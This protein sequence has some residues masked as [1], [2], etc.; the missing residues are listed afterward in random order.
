MIAKLN[1]LGIELD[2][3]DNILFYNEGSF[4]GTPCE[5][6]TDIC[7]SYGIDVDTE[8]IEMNL[9]GFNHYVD[10]FIDENQRE[11]YHIYYRDIKDKILHKMNI[12]NC[13]TNFLGTVNRL[14]SLEIL[15]GD[16]FEK[17]IDIDLN[18]MNFAT[19]ASMY[20][21]YQRDF[22]NGYF[23]H[24]RFMTLMKNMMFEEDFKTFSEIDKEYGK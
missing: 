4:I 11:C 21:I 24:K 9:E 22:K 20:G 3:G 15:L 13:E 17:S 14:D 19:N 18:D 6:T 7:A 5:K 10:I 16:I 8:R 23:K 1:A 12:G 2:L